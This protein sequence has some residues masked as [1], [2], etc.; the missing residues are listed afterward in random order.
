MRILL[1]LQEQSPNVHVLFPDLAIE[2]AY[3]LRLE[4]ELSNWIWER[5]KGNINV[6]LSKWFPTY[7]RICLSTCF[8]ASVYHV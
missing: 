3:C 2:M 1:L 5:R 7:V 4:F 8:H 6:G